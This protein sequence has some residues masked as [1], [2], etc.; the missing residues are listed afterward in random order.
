MRF[1]ATLTSLPV[2]M[3]LPFTD[4]W[5]LPAWQVPTQ[6]FFTNDFGLPLT[7]EP[8]FEDLSC[9]MIFGQAPLPIELDPALQQPCFAKQCSMAERTIVPCPKVAAAA[10]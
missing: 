5:F 2:P 8:N 9:K 3:S 10:T 7:M 6:D 4:T 1:V